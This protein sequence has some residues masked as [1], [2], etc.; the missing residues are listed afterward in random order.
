MNEN[1]AKCERVNAELLKLEHK[2]TFYKNWLNMCGSE[3]SN[4]DRQ[5]YQDQIWA[6]EAELIRK[7][8][9]ACIVYG[10][11]IGTSQAREYL[12]LFHPLRI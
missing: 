6:L 9:H 10:H 3:M 4:E 11:E 12:F 7:L 8:K 1:N 5:S 2:V